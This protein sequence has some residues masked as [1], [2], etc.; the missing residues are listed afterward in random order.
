MVDDVVEGVFVEK[1]ED[2]TV[3]VEDGAMPLVE[4]VS[5]GEA[6]V[7]IPAAD[8]AVVVDDATVVLGANVVVEA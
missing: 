2:S 1:E 4:E 8:A 6:E 5:V 7:P 3:V